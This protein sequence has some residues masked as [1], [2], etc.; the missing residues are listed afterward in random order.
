MGCGS[1]CEGGQQS[2]VV[3]NVE[4]QAAPT[5]AGSVSTSSAGDLITWWHDQNTSEKR[6]LRPEEDR[7]VVRS[8]FFEVSVWSECGEGKDKKQRPFPYFSWPRMGRKKWGYTKDDGADSFDDNGC[9]CTW[10]HFLYSTDVWV[11]VTVL[12]DVDH[13]D[14]S[15]HVIIRPR[16]I[17]E[18]AQSGYWSPEASGKNTVRF[19][20][21]YSDDG[22][23]F[24]LEF[25]WETLILGGACVFHVWFE[26]CGPS[27]LKDTA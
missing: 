15:K 10:A 13:Q 1:S 8:P 20:I 14:I 24:S 23:R 19:K 3:E 25:Q 11:E 17:A 2:G 27:L 4:P 9:T 21:P 5:S 22:F 7:T 6:E 12:G 26:P 16:K 18:S